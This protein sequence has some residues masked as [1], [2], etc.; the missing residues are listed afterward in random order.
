MHVL[1][2]MLFSE[3]LKLGNTNF[4]PNLINT[5]GAS[6]WFPPRGAPPSELTPLQK[7]SGIH[8]PANRLAGGRLTPAYHR[9]ITALTTA[10]LSC[11]CE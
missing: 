10:T 11:I 9:P 7:A 2:D 1:F 4:M 5:G 8:R 3:H 6:A